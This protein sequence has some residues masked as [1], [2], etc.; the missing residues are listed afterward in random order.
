[1][2]TAV[3][4]FL[5]YFGFV[6]FLVSLSLQPKVMEKFS[7]I[8]EAITDRCLNEQVKSD[9]IEQNLAN[10]SG[11]FQKWLKDTKF[12]KETI[13][14]D[15]GYKLVASRLDSK[16]KNT[17]LW[18]LVL[19]GYTGWKEAM[20]AYARMYYKRGYGCIIP[21]LRT[22]GESD[23]DFIGMGWTDHYD[24]MLW[25]KKILEIDPQAKIVIH[26]QSMGAS[27]ALLMSGESDLSSH[28]KAI[29]SDAAYT[30]AYTMFGDKINEWFHLPAFPFIDSAVFILKLR[31]GYDLK[32]ASPINA[33]KKS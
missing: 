4:L 6:Y 24:C 30:D 26:G 15:D 9:D 2:I 10:G 18:A 27:T 29:V 14:S 5:V 21:D 11:S 32:K 13:T 22:Q 12:E 23:G 1:M 7:F 25:I 33:V 20:Y 8:E 3:L 31:G 19:H 17:H 28:V 16:K